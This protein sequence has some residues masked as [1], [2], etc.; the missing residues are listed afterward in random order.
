MAFSSEEYY[1]FSCAHTI[2]WE[3]ISTEL[4]WEMTLRCNID[5]MIN[6]ELK[7][8]LNSTDLNNSIITFCKAAYC[9]VEFVF[10][11]DE[12]LKIDNVIELNIALKCY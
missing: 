2:E 1:W 6:I 4:S 8:T 10:I 3:H 7:S 5:T 12:L 11:I 9:S